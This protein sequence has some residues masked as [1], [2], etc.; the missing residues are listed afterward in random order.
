MP[1]SLN[2]NWI[3]AVWST[4]HRLALIE[5]SFEKKLHEYIADQLRNCGCKVKIVN[6]MSDHI[7][8][9]FLLNRSK[10]IAEVIKQI[11]GSS[12]FYVNQQNWLSLRF[13]WQNG[14]A[15]F[16]VSQRAV[17]RVHAYIKFQKRHHLKCGYKTEMSQISENNSGKPEK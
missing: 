2:Q 17:N 5:P 11:K 7:H 1:H 8:C 6:G 12:S 15:T 16:S 10:S 13:A 3:H 14:Y 4:K 9:L